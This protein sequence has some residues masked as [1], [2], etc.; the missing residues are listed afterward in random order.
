MSFLKKLKHTAIKSK[1]E[2]ES[3]YERVLQ[4]LESGIRRDGLWAQAVEKS[5]GGWHASER[6]TAPLPSG[7][8]PRTRR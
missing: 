6:I 3:L 5:Q 1:F 2:D 7:R 8:A 4:E